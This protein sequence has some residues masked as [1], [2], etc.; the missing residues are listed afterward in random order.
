MVEMSDVLKRHGQEARIEVW[1]DNKVAAELNGT[2]SARFGGTNLE[3]SPEM[4]IGSD[5]PILVLDPESGKTYR[6]DVQVYLVE[7]D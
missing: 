7:H 6:V 4:G 5:E 3:W 2:R 1:L